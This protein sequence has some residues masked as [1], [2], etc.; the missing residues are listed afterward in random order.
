M[1][2]TPSMPMPSPPLPSAVLPSSTLPWPA[3]AESSTS[4]PSPPFVAGRV[5]DQVVVRRQCA[6]LDAGAERAAG[7]VELD[8]GC[9]STRSSAMPPLLPAR[10]LPRTRVSRRELEHDG[11]C[12]SSA[13]M[14]FSRIAVAGRVDDA[15]AAA[16]AVVIVL[17]ST[18]VVVGREQLLADRDAARVVR[19]ASL[20]AT[21]L[22]R[23]PCMTTPAPPEPVI[24]LSSIRFSL[25]ELEADAVAGVA[26][27]GVVADDGVARVAV[28]RDAD[29]C[30]RRRVLSRIVLPVAVAW[31]ASASA[32]PA[33]WLSSSA[34]AGD[35]VAAGA[36]VEQDAVVELG[37]RCRS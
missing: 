18:Q 33:S 14:R 2:P 31:S 32:M 15:D 7:V 17:R 27:E 35:D 8:R 30:W 29:A 10:S 11:R 28:E 24:S 12:R 19:R 16:V 4:M 26:A 22:S 3:G 1:W 5:A 20:S 9:W 36:G 13:A 23:P 34:H 37:D 25:R 6:D 21:T